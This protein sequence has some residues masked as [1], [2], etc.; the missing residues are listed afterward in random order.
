[1]Q[2]LTKKQ[3]ADIE[4]MLHHASIDIRYGD[5]GSYG[6]TSTDAEWREALKNMERARK[7]IETVRTIISK[8]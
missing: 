6:C 3:K 1:M 5:G 7:A 8:M 2:K 4:M